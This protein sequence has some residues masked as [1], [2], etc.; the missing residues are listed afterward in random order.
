MDTGAAPIETFPTAMWNLAGRLG[1][2]RWI[3]TELFGLMGNWVTVTDEPAVRV[4]LSAQSLHHGW[5][6][7]VWLDRFPEFRGLNPQ[8]MCVAPSSEWQELLS[9]ATQLTSTVQRLSV[10]YEQLLPRLIADYEG[11]AESCD[12]VAAPGLVRWV[13]HVL[14]DD[15][16]DLADGLA[17]TARLWV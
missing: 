8:E 6:A 14:L 15:Y 17:L 9:E 13:Q 10:L 2:Y 3:E 12:E 1:G 4:L 11:F 7:D 5:H 16:A